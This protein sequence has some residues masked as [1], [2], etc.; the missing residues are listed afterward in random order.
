LSDEVEAE[1][2]GVKHRH[3][4]EKIEAYQP[5]PPPPAPAPTPPA[6][7]PPPAA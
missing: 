3:R 4:I 5:A 2:G 7:E 6:V 1:V